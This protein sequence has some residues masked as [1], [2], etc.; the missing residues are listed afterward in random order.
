MYTRVNPSYTVSKWDW[1]EVGNLEDGFS[2]DAAWW[3]GYL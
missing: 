1:S 2:R 3:K